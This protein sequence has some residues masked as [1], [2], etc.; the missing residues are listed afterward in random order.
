VKNKNKVVTRLAGAAIVA[1]AAATA[2]ALAQTA[3]VAVAAVATSTS[4]S[5]ER[6]VTV[7]NTGSAPLSLGAAEFPKSFVRG[8]SVAGECEATLLPGEACE[9]TIRFEP[10]QAGLQMG[11]LRI[12]TSDPK[13]PQLVVTLSGTGLP[14]H[15]PEPHGGK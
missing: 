2:P 6:V 13:H 5:N 15:E 10:A 8:A 4:T 14:G 12:S 3:L 9:I 1:M 11:E 7:S